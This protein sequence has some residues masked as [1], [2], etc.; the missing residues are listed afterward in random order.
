MKTMTKLNL[1]IVGACGRGASFK[2][3]CDALKKNVSIHAVCDINEKDLPA[4]RE[5]LGA[6]EQYAN[7]EE[8]LEKSELDAVIIGTPM[9]F[10]VPQA[11]AALERNLH[12]LISQESIAMGGAWLPVPDSREWTG[13]VRKNKLKV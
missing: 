12:V 7:Y 9:H 13:A 2:S 5:R 11:I 4:A 8:M 1:V 10:H 6:R 3:A